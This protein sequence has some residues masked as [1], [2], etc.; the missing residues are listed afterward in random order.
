VDNCLLWEGLY[1]GAGQNVRSP[2][3]EEEGAAEIMCDE[4]TTAP[5]PC[6]P[7]LCRGRR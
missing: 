5:I 6:P 4:L 7:A 3:P 1:T 2:T